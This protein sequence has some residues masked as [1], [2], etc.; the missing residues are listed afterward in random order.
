MAD[1]RK[2]P[3]SDQPHYHDHRQRLRSRFLVDMGA[4][5]PDYELLELVLCGAIP[6]R[7]VKPIAKALIDRFGSFGDVIAADATALAAVPGM[8]E[9]SAILLKS[10]QQAAL[11]LLRHEVS[12]GHVLGSW[13]AVVDYCRAAMSRETVEQFRLFFLNNRNRLIADEV[14]QRG[15]VDH[16]PVY[17]REVVRRALELGA[18]AVIMIHN[19]PSGDPTPSKAD[20]AMTRAIRDALDKIDI[21]LHDHIIIGR[22]D[23][24]SLRAEGLF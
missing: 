4:S 23:T 13:E 2:T 9:S 15:T 18:S 11:R 20:I 14:Q 22:Q 21:R 3:K 7:D 1:A 24:K 16:A 6:R 19:H 8:G 5:M 10:V 12:E 17:P